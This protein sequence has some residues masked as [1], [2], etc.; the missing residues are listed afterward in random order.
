MISAYP[1]PPTPASPSTSQ[2]VFQQIV[3]ERDALK[4]QND[5]LWKL[6]EKQRSVI[7]H[8]RSQLESLQQGQ[9]LP[10][11]N[12]SDTANVNGIPES[13]F[14]ASD[15]QQ[16]QLEDTS[17]V[18]QQLPTP[19]TSPS[20]ND[21]LSKSSKESGIG[22]NGEGSIVS[23]SSKVENREA[24]ASPQ[25][26]SSIPPKNVVWK[27]RKSSLLG[28]SDDEQAMRVA[29]QRQLSAPSLSTQNQSLP[30][31]PTPPALPPRP[32]TSVEYPIPPPRSS[33]SV[34]NDPN[35]Q[36]DSDVSLNF[37]NPSSPLNLNEAQI[38]RLRSSLHTATLP[39]VQ[40]IIRPNHRNKDVASFVMSVRT[41]STPDSELWCVEK[42]YSDFIHLDG[43]IR[44][45]TRQIPNVFNRLPRLPDKTL[46]STHSPAKSDQRRA[47][48]ESYL[49][50]LLILVREHPSMAI[51]PSLLEFVTTNIY[52]P[53]QEPSEDSAIKKEGYL[54]KR[55][56]NWGGWKPRYFVL[57]AYQLDY[58]EQQDGSVSGSIKLQHARCLSLD[59]NINSSAGSNGLDDMDKEYRHA[60][61]IIP[62]NKKGGQQIL[63]AQSDEERDK[64]VKA[65]SAVINGLK[66]QR[67]IQVVSTDSPTPISST[68][69][70]DSQV[71]PS[72]PDPYATSTQSSNTQGKLFNALK[73]PKNLFSNFKNNSQSSSANLRPSH[74]PVFGV[75]LEQ[76]IAIAAIGEGQGIPAVVYRCIE[77]LDAKN[78]AGEEGIYRLS[79]S[80]S[81]IRS[82]KE[83]FNRDGDI[84]LLAEDVY[85]DVH[86]IAGLLKLYLRELPCSI[87]TKQ[88]HSEFL[89][90]IDFSSRDD[91]VIA[92][93][94][95][96]KSLPPQNYA[97]LRALITHLISVVNNSAKNKMTVRN[98]G[99]VFSPTLG[100]PAGVFTLLMTE[101]EVVFDLSSTSRRDSQVSSELTV[102]EVEPKQTEELQHQSRNIPVEEVKE[103]DSGT[104]QQFTRGNRR[105]QYFNS[106]QQDML[107]D[108]INNGIPPPLPEGAQENGELPHRQDGKT[109]RKGS[110]RKNRKSVLF[111]ESASEAIARSSVIVEPRDDESNDEYDAGED[112]FQDAV[113][114]NVVISTKVNDIPMVESPILE[115]QLPSVTLSDE[116]ETQDA[117]GEDFLSLMDSTPDQT[118][119]DV[120]EAVATDSTQKN[121]SEQKPNDKKKARMSY[122]NYYQGAEALDYI[123]ILEAEE[124]LA[125]LPLP[126]QVNL[127]LAPADVPTSSSSPP[128][129]PPSS[130]EKSDVTKS[131]SET[132]KVVPLNLKPN[133]TTAPLNDASLVSPTTSTF[134]EDS[135]RGVRFAKETT[136]IEHLCEADAAS[137]YSAQEAKQNEAEQGESDEPKFVMRGTPGE[138]GSNDRHHSPPRQATFP[139][140]R[141]KST[142]STAHRQRSNSSGN[143]HPSSRSSTR[144]SRDRRNNRGSF[145]PSM[146]QQQNGAEEP[147]RT[148]SPSRN[149]HL[150]HLH[151]P[152]AYRNSISDSP[153]PAP[154][155][156]P[157]PA[158]YV[159][160]P[161]SIQQRSDSFIY[162]PV[163]SQS[164]TSVTSAAS[165]TSLASTVTNSTSPPS[166][167]ESPNNP[168]Q[169]Q[170]Q[171]QSVPKSNE[172]KLTDQN[173]ML[174]ITDETISKLLSADRESLQKYLS[175][176]DPKQ[177]A[178]LQTL[179]MSKVGGIGKA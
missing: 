108:Y 42:L 174:Q 135:R 144:S 163:R 17:S 92:L 93:S 44:F 123:D 35:S 133:V 76:A 12:S 112:E 119:T 78:A 124:T 29:Q 54:I 106:A 115:L 128:P 175:G 67:V 132:S 103:R 172:I 94:Q 151:Q 120:Q 4:S 56:K 36:T 91:R 66:S 11:S 5:Q 52:S 167:P 168:Y 137:E 62:E 161:L 118:E 95:L 7:F 170:S 63:C 127:E 138:N 125:S 51:I 15:D 72:A 155:P 104:P 96:V 101:F 49:S 28:D 166:P 9:P 122:L 18:S 86:A 20:T 90:V 126:S 81:A 165:P 65:I 24:T 148:S 75:P 1:P 98:I 2:D 178:Q 149:P 32:S 25:P 158:G 97:L 107:S 129:S 57:T 21:L 80:T 99:I 169:S 159:P 102:S 60:F 173:G 69:S 111:D 58:L 10:D 34:T 153:S 179:L 147:Q 139:P 89:H 64:W 85:Y 16:Q 83:R 48:L 3:A 145:H 157:A 30:P 71:P 100:V 41:D 136:I 50:Y 37:S 53:P 27:P 117:T 26:S 73:Q 162:E 38:A 14:S 146:I 143:K 131:S 31:Q 140:P 55:G 109:S 105:S 87:L 177:L 152:A 141:S 46:F 160:H 79:G 130:N 82:L 121:T 116:G 59:S 6:V 74:G 77:Y 39:V 8:L 68:P 23:V 40:S 13:S 150:H 110:H 176:M 47:A 113:T 88:L 156:P 154:S 61:A 164:P 84:N 114:D 33:S 134:T 142:S 45:Q 70:T 22:G 43:K 171:S 19:N